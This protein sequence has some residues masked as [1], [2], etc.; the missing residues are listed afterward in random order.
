[1]PRPLPSYTLFPG[2]SE[3]MQDIE[4]IHTYIHLHLINIPALKALVCY[5]QCEQ[6]F[7]IRILKKRKHNYYKTIIIKQMCRGCV[8]AYSSL[9]LNKGFIIFIFIPC[10]L[11][12][13]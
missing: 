13:L 7:K 6:L 10:P 2:S 12:L 11:T 3:Q 8:I 9:L 4:Y 1:M 5:N